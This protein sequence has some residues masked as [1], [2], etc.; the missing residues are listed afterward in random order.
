M[1]HMPKHIVALRDGVSDSQMETTKN[2]EVQ[3]I[4]EACRRFSDEHNKPQFKP[5]ISYVVVQKRIPT[6]AIPAN[7]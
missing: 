1:G 4:A 7:P 3:H 2:I 5:T 6:R